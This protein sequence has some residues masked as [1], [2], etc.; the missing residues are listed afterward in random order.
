MAKDAPFYVCWRGNMFRHS[1]YGIT[2]YECPRLTKRKTVPVS[3]LDL[4][5]IPEP[6]D[7][8]VWVILR[9]DLAVE[10]GRFTLPDVH[11]TNLPWNRWGQCNE[12]I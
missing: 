3:R 12:R 4:D 5:A 2:A 6:F 10:E 9:L 7:T 8:E 11:V 1:Y